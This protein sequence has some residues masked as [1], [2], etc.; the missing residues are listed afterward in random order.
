MRMQPANE[1]TN[2]NVLKKKC[3]RNEIKNSVT[4]STQYKI[5][6]LCLDLSCFRCH[7]IFVETS[8]RVPNQLRFPGLRIVKY[9]CQQ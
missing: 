9:Y 5:K 4:I 8:T 1:D 2:E 7:I 6:C 3:S